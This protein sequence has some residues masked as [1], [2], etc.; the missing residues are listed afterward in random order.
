MRV[1][2]FE[3]VTGGGMSSIALPRSLALE[4]EL[5]ARALVRD[6]LDVPNIDL[7]VM[8]DIR[9]P[10]P[11][12]STDVQIQYVLREQDAMEVLRLCLDLVDAVWPI[13]PETDGALEA[14]SDAVIAGGKILLNSIP[15]A[16]HVA[17]SKRKTAQVLERAGVPV[18]PVHS[19]DTGLFEWCETWVIK[20]DDGAGCSGIR[21]CRDEWE[22]MRAVEALGI[23]SN[24]VAQPYVSG[25]AM[26][27][28]LICHHGTVRLLSC[29]TQRV[30]IVNDEFRL[31]GCIV[32]GSRMDRRQAL[33]LAREVVAAIPGLWGYIGI[34]FIFGEE[35]PQILE[36]NP[37]LTTS[38]VGLKRSIG[39][40]PARLVVDLV[41]EQSRLNSAI[42]S[43]AQID[44]TPVE[45]DFG[46]TH[47]T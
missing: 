7:L 13:A 19:P 23:E 30:A 37:R 35:N 36:V 6:L 12:C 15:R 21:I 3:Y 5:M 45:V 39:V 34:D 1:L 18:V 29:N 10:A 47:D 2:V 9:L 27:M 24:Y 16:V 11:D 46:I 26:S 44:S 14:I 25:P 4:G 40:N 43:G 28:S 17:A 32:N 41:D 42:V 8:R 33:Q 22:M 20:P 38:Y 31:L